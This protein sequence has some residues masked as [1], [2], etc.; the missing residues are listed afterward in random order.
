MSYHWDP[1]RSLRIL[2]V[3]LF[4]LPW[5]TIVSPSDGRFR[6]ALAL[7]SSLLSLHLAPGGKHYFIFMGSWLLLLPHSWGSRQTGLQIRLFV[8]THKY[9]DV[10]FEMSRVYTAMV[11]VVCWRRPEEQREWKY[12]RDRVA[13]NTKLSGGLAHPGGRELSKWRNAKNGDTGDERSQNTIE[14]PT[15]GTGND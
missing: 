11:A 6:P 8:C 14:F 13:S 4:R 3:L 9:V 2:W 10:T 7:W 1:W 5:N 12:E 15:W